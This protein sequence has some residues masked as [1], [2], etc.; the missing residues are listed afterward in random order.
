MFKIVRKPDASPAQE[1]V[2][3]VTAVVC[4]LAASALVLA[5]LGFNPFEVFG[6][7]V[8]GS[9]LSSH[10]L[11]S[12]LNKTIPLVVLSLGIAIAFKMKFWTSVPK[13]SSTWA[14]LVHPWRPSVSTSCQLS[15]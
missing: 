7:I 4:A 14:L 2:M 10:R 12:T 6:K 5:L 11:V 1:R 9:L 15:C 13:D 8:E 3:R